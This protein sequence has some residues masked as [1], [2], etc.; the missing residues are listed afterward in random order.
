MVSQL[1][2]P[3]KNLS[4][5]LANY[6]RGQA[7]L[8]RVDEILNADEMVKE[9][10][11]SVPITEF[12]DSLSFH[13]VSFS[14]GEKEV[15]S[16]I[17]LTLSKGSFIAL[18]GES[19]S[20]KSTMADLLMRFYEPTSGQILIDGRDIRDYT[21]SSYHSLFGFVSQ[22]VVLFN[23]TLYNNLTL[24]LEDV[25]EDR[26]EEA[27]RVADIYDFVKDLPGGLQYSLTD[28]GLNLSG[29]QRQRISIAR[30]VLRQALI[31]VLDEA[32]SAM[33]TQSEQ[34]FMKALNNLK[35][36]HTLLVI[37]HRLST[38]RQADCIYVMENGVFVQQ[39]THDSLKDEDGKYKMLLTINELR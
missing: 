11:G 23:D 20:G 27:L 30:A 37:A 38:I 22:D 6:K 1:V 18:A 34:S 16:H 7:A 35:Q 9:T 3:V 4:T 39:G 8:D 33:D 29:G 25:S 17:D 21:L 31:L 10:P 14:Y 19:G 28:R 15:L 2:P 26:I 36:D 24:G 12:M 32:T 5:A 13:D